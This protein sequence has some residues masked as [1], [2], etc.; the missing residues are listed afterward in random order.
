L[1]T[2]SEDDYANFKSLLDG[3]YEP[4]TPTSL[5]NDN[6]FPLARKTRRGSSSD[7]RR[8][9]KVDR[10]VCLLTGASGRLGSAICE[11][12]ADRYDFAAVHRL[13]PVAAGVFEIEAD[14]TTESECE[15]TVEVALAHF[16]RI[17]LVVNAAVSSAWGPMLDSNEL[18]ASAP[19]QFLVNVVAPLWIS[20]AVGRLFWKKD[21][22]ANRARNRSVINVS[23]ISGQNFFAAEGQ[24]VYAATKAALDHLTGHMALEFAHIGVRVNA[25]A[26]NSFPSNVPTERVIAAIESLDTGELSG[27]IVVVDGDH[28]RI[29][30]LFS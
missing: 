14:L 27:S 16:G 8:S 11:G 4:G 28:D 15:R 22:D 3:Y 25:V 30:R 18:S 2:G 10:R 12:L 6:P 20:N 29:V 5:V 9:E 7:S 23:S 24:S 13:R 21:P 17:D 19:R 1:L 26:P